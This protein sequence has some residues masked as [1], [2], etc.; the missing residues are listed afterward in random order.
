MGS[1]RNLNSQF[2]GGGKVTTFSPATA[3]RWVKFVDQG[4]WVF[5]F[6][7]RDFSRW[8]GARFTPGAWSNASAYKCMRQKFGSGIKAVARGK[9]GT[10]L[11]AA[12][13]KLNTGPF[14]NY[15]WK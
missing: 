3:N 13:N 5:K 1:F 7:N 8:F 4:V 6:H 2:T 10:W 12:S 11:V 9:S 14:R 15:T